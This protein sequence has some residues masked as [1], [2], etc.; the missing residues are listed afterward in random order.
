MSKKS[1]TSS[2]AENTIQTSVS[3]RHHRS[4]ISKFV[5]TDNYLTVCTSVSCTSSDLYF[6][7]TYIIIASSLLQI[8]AVMLWRHHVA[9]T[10]SENFWL[11]RSFLYYGVFKK[12]SKIKNEY[13]I[14]LNIDFNCTVVCHLK[15]L[16]ANGN[17]KTQNNEGVVRIKGQQNHYFKE[18]WLRN[19]STSVVD[20]CP[21]CFLITQITLPSCFV[22]WSHCSSN[23]LTKI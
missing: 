11:V 17:G 1:G 21:R 8:F 18:F 9:V 20:V 23:K 15:Q 3:L 12:Y 14:I 6:L 22:T 19:G 5:N 4:I 7:K 16:A 2:L 13:N 10:K